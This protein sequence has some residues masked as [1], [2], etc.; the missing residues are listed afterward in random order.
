MPPTPAPGATAVAFDDVAAERLADRLDRLA[1]S[2]RNAE[3]DHAEAAAA[4]RPDWHGFTRTWFDAAV[5][6]LGAT[7][8]QAGTAAGHAAD[9]IR[10]AMVNA[11]L[12]Q[13]QM[14]EAAMRSQ[15]QALLAAAQPQ[16]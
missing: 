10:R 4:A 9:T 13:V 16:P 11:S 15:R 12:Q 2:L 8:R 6:E 14:N 7:L 1:Q 5:H 3:R